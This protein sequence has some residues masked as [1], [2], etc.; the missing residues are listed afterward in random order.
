MIS[1]FFFFTYWQSA[2]ASYNTTSALRSSPAISVE[3]YQ[4][5]IDR[6]C[7][8]PKGRYSYVPP[9]PKRWV[10][11]SV[12]TF[13]I[14]CFL[15]IITVFRGFSISRNGAFLTYFS[16]TYSLTFGVSRAS[17]WSLKSL[18]RF[19][20]LTALPLAREVRTR[21]LVREALNVRL[22]VTCSYT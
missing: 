9:K 8:H 17:R 12:I 10:N 2:S 14:L 1:K 22:L 18:V 5:S 4:L 7:A 6:V 19:A 13:C 16:I 3:A 11:M 15:L 21:T 20:L